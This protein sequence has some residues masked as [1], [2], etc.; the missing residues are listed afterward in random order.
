LL[1]PYLCRGHGLPVHVRQFRSTIC[2]TPATDTVLG[3]GT[4]SHVTL[5]LRRTPG[6]CPIHCGL[7]AESVNHT[8]VTPA[9]RAF[10]VRALAAGT[11]RCE[12][13]TSTPMSAWGP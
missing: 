11:V 12:R 13:W 1:Q 4:L 8:D 6:T 7:R 5:G 2:R 9:W 3:R 10:V